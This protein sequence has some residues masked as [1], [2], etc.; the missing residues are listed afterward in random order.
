MKLQIDTENKTIKVEQYVVFSD[1]IRVLNKLLPKE[2]RN[3]TLEPN[4]IIYSWYPH[5]TYYYPTIEPIKWEVTSGTTTY[6]AKHADTITS[7]VYNIEVL[8]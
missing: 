4:T 7:S 1:L 6:D 8:N 5:Y 2:W 3:Y